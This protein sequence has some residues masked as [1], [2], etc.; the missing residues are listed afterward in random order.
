M[1]RKDTH[2]LEEMLGSTHPY[3]IADYMQNNTNDLI[4][5]NDGFARYIRELLKKKKLQQKVVFMRADISEKY[6]YELLRG[7][8][9]VTRKRDVILRF[10]Y[11]AEFTLE[12][13]QYALRLYHMDTLYARDPR[14]AL[15]MSCLKHKLN[16]K[17]DCI[18]NLNDLLE[19][20]NM[21]PLQP[22]GAS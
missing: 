22:V 10:C 9:K 3:H 8:K 13:T 15:I 16:C 6:G 4:A 11:A 1:F 2:M 7:G 21:T 17:P 14:D 20:N 5:G 12:E 19:R 18:D